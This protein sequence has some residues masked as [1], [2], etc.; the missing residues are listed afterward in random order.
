MPHVGVATAIAGVL[1]IGSGV[2]QEVFGLAPAMAVNFVLLVP[3]AYVAGRALTRCVA[4]ECSGRWPAS[5]RRLRAQWGSTT[6]GD[7]DESS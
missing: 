7:V 1:Y 5:V 2:A 3:A 4:V 6:K